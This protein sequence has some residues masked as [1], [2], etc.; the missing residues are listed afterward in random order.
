MQLSIIIVNYNVK[1]FLEQCLCSVVKACVNIQ[2]EIFVVDN[3]S[4]DGS[5]DFFSGRFPQVKFI[6]KNE[7]AGFAKACNEALQYTCGE[8]ILFLNPDTIVAEDC[9]EKCIAFLN[10]TAASGALGVRMIDGSGQYLPESKRGFPSLRTSFFKMAGLTALFPQSKFFAPYY[11]GH[12]PQHTN[13]QVDVLCGAFMLVK[14]KALEKAGVFDETFFM[15]GEDIDLSYRIQKAGFANYYFADTTIIHFKGESTQKKGMNY[16]KIFYGAMRLFVQKH[17]APANAGAYVFFIQ[18]AIF[19]RAGLAAVSGL[20]SNKKKYGSYRNSSVT[21][22]NKKAAEEAAEILRVTGSS[23]LLKGNIDAENFANTSVTIQ[24]KSQLEK[25]GADEIIFCENGFSFKEIIHV[26][27]QLPQG[28]RSSFYA[29]GSRS[30][31]SSS[32]KQT[33]GEF[34]AAK[35]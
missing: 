1:Y 20:F 33:N 26:L 21:A 35:H 6:W 25:F 31:V 34:I 15:Y 3:Q 9:F 2:A 19:F 4:T 29:A 7:N 28:I 14:K 24:L 22:G 30:I 5:S 23:I 8:N 17:Y 13:N 12:L 27:Q 10:S 11:L 18:T 16:L 32:S